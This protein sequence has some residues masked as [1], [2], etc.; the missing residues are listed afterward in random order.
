MPPVTSSFSKTTT[1]NLSGCFEKA[2]AAERP[3]APAP[4]M[5]TRWVF[6]FVVDKNHVIR[7]KR[8]KGKKKGIQ[9]HRS[10]DAIIAWAHNKQ[11]TERTRTD[12]ALRIL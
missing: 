3:A 8:L 11:N 5:A 12:A 1:M 9:I 2:Y 4:T 6:M 7:S 10:N